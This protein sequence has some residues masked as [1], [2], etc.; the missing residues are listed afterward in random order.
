[1]LGSPSTPKL[2]E[3]DEPPEGF[4]FPDWQAPLDVDA[5]LR[6]VPAA[7]TAKGMFFH[8]IYKELE[9]AGKPLEAKRSYHSFSDYPLTD[10]MVLVAEA[11]G[12]LYPE[13]TLRNAIRH[14]ARLTHETFAASTLG[15]VMTAGL[16]GNIPGLLKIAAKTIPY[17]MKPGRV[18]LTQLESDRAILYGEEL[19]IFIDCF[20]LGVNEGILKVHGKTGVMAQK[21]ESFHSGYLYM[22]WK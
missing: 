16:R 4:S 14:L 9:R 3:A 20:F 1:M 15:R 2:P 11:A 10:C 13:K 21:Q 22:S 17:S 18:E 19:Y 8:S 6:R 12:I 5:Y 7:A